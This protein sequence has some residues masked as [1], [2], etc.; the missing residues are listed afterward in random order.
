MA[1]FFSRLRGRDGGKKS[2]NGNQDDLEKAPAKRWEDDSMRTYVEPEEIQELIRRCTEELKSR[3][4]CG[5]NHPPSFAPAPLV[6][7]CM[8]PELRRG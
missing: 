2:K 5:L 6:L 1:R 8:A 7:Y 3:G 4:M